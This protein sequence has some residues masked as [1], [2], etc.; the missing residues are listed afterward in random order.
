MGLNVLLMFILAVFALANNTTTAATNATTVAATTVAAGTTKG[1]AGDASGA[2]GM[3]LN[4]LLLFVLA[5]VGFA[6]NNTTAG[7]T[8]TTAGASGKAN[9]ASAAM[10]AS[11]PFVGLLL[12][13]MNAMRA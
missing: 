2:H 5:M 6:S 8:T 13:G 9:D 7:G 11:L 3:G 4:V 10:I 1:A 12:V